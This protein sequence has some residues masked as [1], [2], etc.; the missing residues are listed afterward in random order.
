MID[1]RLPGA[2]AP[3]T[4]PIP[5]VPLPTGDTHTHVPI[6]PK[7]GANAQGIDLTDLTKKAIESAVPDAVGEDQAPGRAKEA[8]AVLDKARTWYTKHG[9]GKLEGNGPTPELRFSDQL[10]NAFYAGTPRASASAVPDW[11]VIVFG[12]MPKDGFHK[13]G[14]AA[15]DAKN[16]ADL[17]QQLFAPPGMPFEHAEDVIIHEYTHRITNHI[18]APNSVMIEGAPGVLG[19]HIS[20]VMS[21][22][23]TN[24]ASGILGEKVLPGGVRSLKDPGRMQDAIHGHPLPAKAKEYVVNVT[25]QG[26]AH[27]NVGIPN[28]AA[29]TI[30][31]A[32]GPE[33]TGELYAHTLLNQARGQATPSIRTW[34]KWTH[35][36]AQEMDASGKLAATVVDAW[37]GVGLDPRPW[38]ARLAEHLH[39]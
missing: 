20:D 29:Q 37:K 30:I 23:I 25:D 15:K 26:G 34:A 18:F 38:T 10:E 5:G 28:R 13:G 36:A 9:F 11:E 12:R 21:K 22:A 14:G 4:L 33:V 35:E 7:P 19:E 6:L 27:I 3:Y 32:H 1:S 16:G 8:H 2:N 24:D 31:E 17:L 39:F